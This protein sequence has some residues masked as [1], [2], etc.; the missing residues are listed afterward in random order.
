MLNSFLEALFVMLVIPFA[1]AG[2]F[3]VFFLHGKPMSLFAMMGVVGLAGVVVNGSIVMVDSIHRRI[4]EAKGTADESSADDDRHIVDAVVER[5]RP[6]LVTT[7]TTLGGVLPTAY[8][9][10]G[11]D[12]IVS[13]IS[14]AI[15]WGLALSTLTT[16]YLVPV[17]Y[18][19][20]RDLRAKLSFGKVPDNHGASVAGAADSA[21]PN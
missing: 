16:L 2:V 8:G 9:I 11:Y 7:L 14:L 13:V 3:L 10:G 12:P 19:S 20:A 4:S 1:V 15:G 17:L 5:L 6:I 21:T 18:A